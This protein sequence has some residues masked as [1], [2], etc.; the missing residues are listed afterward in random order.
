MKGAKLKRVDKGL[1]NFLKK[2]ER[3][4]RSM[5]LPSVRC[6][7]IECLHQSPLRFSQKALPLSLTTLLK[8]PAVNARKDMQG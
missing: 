1:S 8:R 6:S 7:S 5:I 2:F 4:S 3:I